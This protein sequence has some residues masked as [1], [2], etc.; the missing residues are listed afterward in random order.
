LASHAHLTTL[1]LLLENVLQTIDHFIISGLEASISLLEK[2]RNRMG[3]DL[4]WILCLAWKKWIGGTP[5]EH[6]PY[7][8]DLAP[9]PGQDYKQGVIVPPS[10][11][12]SMY[13]L[14][15]QWCPDVHCH[16]GDMLLTDGPCHFE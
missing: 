16:G 9:S 14:S 1:Y 5:L 4:Y 7:S 15:Q 10:V 8:P 3:Q 11:F 6:L 12:P 13:L 2:P